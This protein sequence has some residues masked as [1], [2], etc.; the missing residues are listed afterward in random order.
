MSSSPSQLWKAPF[1][2]DVAIDATITIP[3]SKS[4]TNRALVLAALAESP[5]RLIRPLHSRD[6]DLMAKGLT[7]LGVG[8]R[9]VDGDWEINPGVLRGPASI[10][11]G[12]A[13]TVMRFL[14]AVAALARGIIHFDG[15]PRSHERPLKPLIKALEDLGVTIEH[16]NR[17][18]LPMMINGNGSLRGGEIDV[19]SS[20]SSQFIT[21]LLLIASRTQEGLTLRNFGASL[22]SQPHIDMTLAMIRDF[23]GEVKTSENNLWQVASRPLLGKE[24]LIE[25]DLSNAAPFMAAAMVCGGRVVISDW[26]KTTT[27]PGDQLREIFAAMGAKIEFGG[28]D[29]SVKGTGS[30][31]GIEVDLHDVG[32]LTPTIAAVAALADSP[33]YLKGI[34]HLRLHET[35]RLAALAREINSLGGHV[36][37]EEN[38]LRIEPRDLHAGIFHTY[39]DHRL[40]TAGA[41]IGLRIKG[42]EVENIETT[43]KTLPDFPGLWR[44]IVG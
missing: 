20:S 18:S 17:Y 25:P 29:L 35:D 5:S 12:N 43:R 23:G 16:S 26:P 1:R 4:I 42:I 21:A 30:I 34:G 37:E 11:V 7:S 2:A 24:I 6:S 40:A 19:D 38:A 44:E 13:G 10:D 8:I 32:E 39:D 27:Q 9:E 36:I 41:V 22:P 31:H 33:S 28:S 3:G 14:P 15:D